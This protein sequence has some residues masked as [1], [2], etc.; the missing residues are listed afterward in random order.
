MVVLQP[1]VRA[2]AR[3]V[4][5]DACAVILIRG[6]AEDLEA[7]AG[8]LCT[9]IFVAIGSLSCPYIVL[10]EGIVGGDANLSALGHGLLVPLNL[11]GRHHC[12][13]S[14]GI[15]AR[16]TM[17]EDIPLAVDF[18]QRAVGVM[19]RIRGHNLRTILIEH[20]ATAIDKNATGTPGA[21]GRIAVSI[22][23]R[24]VGVSEAIL[25]AAVA[26][27]DHHIL[28]AD[29]TNAGGLE[30]VEVQR[31]LA[32]VESRVFAAFLVQEATV[33]TAGR[34]EGV[35]DLGAGTH[36]VHI[37]GIELIGSGVLEA[38]E[39]ISTEAACKV[40]ILLVGDGLDEDAGVEI[41]QR[42]FNAGAA[43]GRQVNGRK[44]TIGTVALAD[45]SHTAPSAGVRIEP[46]GLLASGLVS[47]L[48]QIWRKHRIPAAIY[49]IGK[50]G[51][52]IAPLREVFDGCRPHPD[53]VATIFAEVSVV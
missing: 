49:E 35:N 7:L 20:H 53:I 38:V 11:D 48:H 27:E 26:G 34:D 15:A 28:V 43:I 36:S 31:V 33:M 29:L 51:T 1:F 30:E 41:Y 10:S 23:Q 21:E 19:G 50:D 39:D 6:Q 3:H 22:T 44:G 9:T 32:L 2:G 5:G 46:I 37:I 18:L 12:L 16:W 47:D 14:V 4:A 40:G 8:D 45:H 42:A 25:L 17:V 24:A 13:T 52:L